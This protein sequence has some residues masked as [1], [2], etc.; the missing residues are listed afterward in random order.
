VQGFL[1]KN[2]LNGEMT[3]M[4]TVTWHKQ[5]NK[6][7]ILF[8]SPIHGIFEKPSFQGYVNHRNKQ[9]I[10]KWSSRSHLNASTS[11][12]TPLPMC[13]EKIREKSQFEKK[14]SKVVELFSV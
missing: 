5:D 4:F 1:E 8:P 12:K 2:Q 3:N 10:G 6:A 7:L 9:Y 13:T 14:S 11:S